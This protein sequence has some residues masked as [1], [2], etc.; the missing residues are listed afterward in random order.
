[1]RALYEVLRRNSPKG[2][3]VSVIARGTD[4]THPFP[5]E[6]EP[7]RRRSPEEEICR[8][9]RDGPGRQQ[10]VYT[11]RCM[12]LRFEWDEKKANHNIEK[13]GVPFEDAATVL[14]DPLSLT[15]DDPM[16]S[17]EEQRSVTVGESVKGELLVVVHTDREDLIRIISARKATRRERRDYERI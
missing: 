7:E 11:P 15:I 14:G 5:S 8:R 10:V 12:S 4:P 6:N 16:H 1:M 13:H 9:E 17:R 3:P 2:I